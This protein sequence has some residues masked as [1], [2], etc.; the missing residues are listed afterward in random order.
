MT[1]VRERRQ[2]RTHKAY[3]STQESRVL[4]TAAACSNCEHSARVSVKDAQLVCKLHGQD[5]E[6]RFVCI[7]H[8]RAAGSAF[9]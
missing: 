6:R 4:I 7:A 9:N 5:V 1:L 2:Y 8:R 3:Y